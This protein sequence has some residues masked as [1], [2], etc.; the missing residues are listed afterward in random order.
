MKEYGKVSESEMKVMNI[1]WQSGDAVTASMVQ[2]SLH[3]ETGWKPTTVLTFL[4]RLVEKGLLFARK[5][6]KT[7]YYTAAVTEEEYR[8]LET[9]EFVREVHHG[10]LRSLIASMYESEGISDE[11]LKELKSWFEEKTGEQ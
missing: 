3:E 2:Q 4:S 5:E 1:V 6:G 11:D 7:N 10:S 9:R 8:G